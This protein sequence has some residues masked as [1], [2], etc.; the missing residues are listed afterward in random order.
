MAALAK[1]IQHAAVWRSRRVV[2]N[3]RD[4]KESFGVYLNRR[5]AEPVQVDPRIKYPCYKS[6]DESIDVERLKS[7]DSYLKKKVASHLENVQCQEFHT[8][9]QRL[10]VLSPAKPGSKVIPLAV[11]TRP[12]RYH[13]ITKPDLWEPSEYAS[14]FAEL[15]DFI[16]TL[17]FKATSRMII[18]AD[19]KGRAVTA[20]RD[21][22]KT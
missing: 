21:H 20:H 8:G 2:D 22:A 5:R 15:I 4:I 9:A 3:I 7:L 10:K 14:D 13:D 11:S 6:L 17:P 18:M 19:D 16:D 12:F 1:R